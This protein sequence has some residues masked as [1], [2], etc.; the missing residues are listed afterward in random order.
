MKV[1]V[2]GAGPAGIRAVEQLVRSGL[3]PTWI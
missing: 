3:C 1:V 2:V